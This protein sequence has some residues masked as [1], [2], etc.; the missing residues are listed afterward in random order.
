MLS[1]SYPHPEERPEGASRRTQDGNAALPR[2]SCPASQRIPPESE[3]GHTP[4]MPDYRR[5][6]VPGGTSFFTVNLL[7]GMEHEEAA[8]LAGL[9]RARAQIPAE[10]ASAFPPCGCLCSSLQIATT[11]LP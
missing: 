3:L 7:E 9:N 4:H 11:K 5:N 10:C 8:R 1:K 6:R 2:N